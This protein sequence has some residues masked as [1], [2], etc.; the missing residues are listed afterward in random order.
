[1][2]GFWRFLGDRP[3]AFG[4]PGNGRS[5]KLVL[6]S[7]R[8]DRGVRRGL[9]GAGCSAGR[10]GAYRPLVIDNKVEGCLF[11][12]HAGVKFRV[13]KDALKLIE[14]GIHPRPGGAHSLGSVKDKYLPGASGRQRFDQ[15][16]IDHG[17]SHPSLHPG[18]GV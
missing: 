15:R 18:S 14:E 5:A 11:L 6:D 1:M 8:K 16:G 3:D 4:A 9:F 12:H 10:G 17:A 2:Q 13:E 7:D